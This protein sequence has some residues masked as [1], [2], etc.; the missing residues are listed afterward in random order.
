MKMKGITKNVAASI[1]SAILI[2]L[3][4]FVWN[5][6]FCKPSDISGVWQVECYVLKSN[7]SEYEGMTLFFDVLLQQNG[8]EITGTGE[9]VAEKSKGGEKYEFERDKRVHIE[10]TGKLRNNFIIDDKVFLHFVEH[11]RIRESS[12]VENMKILSNKL[13]EG[14]FFSTAADSSGKTFWKKK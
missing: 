10:I 2:A 11:G 13:M 6:F 1:I 14:T 12:T 3:I 5:D 4:F 8:R 7:H 9:K